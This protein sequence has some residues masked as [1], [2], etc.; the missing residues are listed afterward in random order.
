MNDR[1]NM[2]DRIPPQNIDAE[3]SV[4]GAVLLDSKCLA[5]VSRLLDHRSFYS[6]AH[7]MIFSAMHILFNDSKPIDAITLQNQMESEGTLEDAGGLAYLADLTSSVPTSANVQHYA[8]IVERSYRL[9]QIISHASNAMNR[10]WDDGDPDTILAGL[11]GD[12]L[13][14][15]ARE[16]K[17]LEHI[18]ALTGKT[19]THLDSIRDQTSEGVGV[20]SGI[21]D[22][23]AICCGFMPGEVCVLAARPSVG[24]SAIAANIAV[25]AA[26]AGKTVLF[27]TL[28]MSAEATIG[29]MLGIHSQF[30]TFEYKTQYAG[31][32]LKDD[33]SRAV[34]KLNNLN[35]Y[36]HDGVNLTWDEVYASSWMHN[37]VHGQPSLIIIDYIQLL[38]L[39]DAPDNRQQELS[40]ISRGIKNMSRDLQ[41]PILTLSQI[42][43]AG[44]TGK[45]ILSHIRDS[46]AIEQDADYV[47]LV[48]RDTVSP[49]GNFVLNLDVAKNRDGP[50]GECRVVFKRHTQQILSLQ[51]TPV[52]EPEE[53]IDEEEEL[54]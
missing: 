2:N 14:C 9:R 46:G 16:R 43:R 6:P 19:K 39:K 54:F 32:T 24:K 35:I 40:N 41:C 5:K 21:R 49:N 12:L 11:R 48:S 1:L 20:L 13:Q 31:D 52:K 18:S 30:S 26:M 50:T 45:P 27:Y 34:T 53:P 33:L 15:E 36:I 51:K 25:S 22:L 29:R 7:Q 23:D 44:D 10:V 47:I 28:E 8:E 4:L 38:T 3:R 17:D 37:E 42:N